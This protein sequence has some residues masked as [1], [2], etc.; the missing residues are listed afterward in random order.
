MAGLDVAMIP[1][2]QLNFK[3]TTK[4]DLDRFRLEVPAEQIGR[5]ISDI[6][7]M[8]GEHS[9][10]ETIGSRSVLMGTA[11]AAAMTGYGSEVAAYTGGK[12]KFAC[13][14]DGYRPCLRQ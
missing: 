1:G 13:R 14:L 9:T 2:N 6:R 4:E 7:Q 8:G 10:P 12:G 11:P 3:V 5:A